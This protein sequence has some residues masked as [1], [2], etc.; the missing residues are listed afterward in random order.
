M[1]NENQS[2]Q[3]E[4]KHITLGLVL[5]WI[6]G[7]FLAVGGFAM[8]F[9]KPLPGILILIA[10]AVALPPINKELKKKFNFSLSGGVRTVLVLALC[11]VAG[12][13]LNKGTPPAQSVPAAPDTTTV[14]APASQPAVT[15][16]V[17]HP[18]SALPPTPVVAAAPQTLLDV[19]GSGTKTTQSFTAA[20]DWTLGYSYN[21][22]NFGDQ[23]NFQVYVYNS[24]GSMSFDNAGVNE[25]GKSGSDTEYYHK[26][27]S[28]Y[29]E[30]NSE[31]NWHVVVKG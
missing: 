7:I 27:G 25:L 12:V 10:G 29:L 18:T 23:G 20:G 31:C 16:A 17:N 2:P 11:I 15:A 9:S 13:S 8:L 1:D 22:S 3:K 30:M 19:S 21:C 24:D 26:G 6:V 5:A 4:T 14:S 28:Y